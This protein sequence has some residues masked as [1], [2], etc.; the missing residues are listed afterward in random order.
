MSIY[1]IRSKS[2]AATRASAA[3]A[4]RLSGSRRQAQV[5]EVLS[6]RMDDPADQEIQ[7]WVA[8]AHGVGVQKISHGERSTPVTGTV[9]VEMPDAEAERLRREVRDVSVMRDQALELIRPERATLGRIHQ[10]TTEE[11]WHLRAIGL[12]A[13]RSDGFQGSGSGVT[14][15]VLDTGIDATHAELTGKVDGAYTFN[16]Q[17]WQAEAQ[18]S[19][20]D[21][22]GHGTHVAG[23]I[24]GTTIGVAPGARVINGMMLPQGVGKLSNFI[25][26]LEWAAQR[27]EVQIVNMSAGLPGYLPEMREAVADLLSVGVLFICATGNEGRNRTRS[28]GNYI[29]ALSVGAV[30]SRG[31]V[32]S[33]SSSGILVA[34]HHQY[35]V[36]DLVA[37]GEAV[38]SSVMGGG[39][40]AWNGTSMATPIVAGVAALI[41]EK[42]PEITVI[43]LE[44]A[45]LST[46]SS[47]ASSPDRQGRGLLQVKAAL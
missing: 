12:D 16:V 24:C 28:P 25:L 10:V 29:E 3:T 11:L 47:L 2:L 38:Y 27:P 40:E 22:E 13:A 5:A 34:D 4:R 1:I 39:Y 36:P 7:R 35:I 23:L 30:D 45:I 18:A 43:E 19:S 44:E 46:C 6:L 32:A 14:V 8:D 17:S 37:P 26:A 9:I 42:Y 20:I 33:F 41:L 15:A 21:T 31:R